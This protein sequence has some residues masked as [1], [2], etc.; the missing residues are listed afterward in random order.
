VDA[1]RNLL[2]SALAAAVVLVPFARHL[3]VD[4][5][6]PLAANGSLTAGRARTIFQFDPL[7]GAFDE[8]RPADPD[9]P[10]RFEQYFEFER[11][12]TDRSRDAIADLIEPI[13]PGVCRLERRKRLIAAIR[14]YYDA[15]SRQKAS[16]RL[17]GPRASRF[18]EQA[19]STATD[20]RID[21]FV[22]QL[23][24]LGFLQPGDLSPRSYPDLLEIIGNVSV[25]ATACPGTKFGD[26][27]GITGAPTFWS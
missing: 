10:N 2:A 16:F 7:L 12:W 8:A 4:P 9:D 1:V 14:T 3:P 20:R 24:T 11:N 5:D 18:I 25:P 13:G 22:R 19:W 15:R 23:V 6:E 17:R 26:R 27:Q 21:S